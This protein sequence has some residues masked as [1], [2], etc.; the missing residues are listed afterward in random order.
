MGMIRLLAPALCLVL[1]VL[2]APTALAQSDAAP[3]ASGQQMADTRWEQTRRLLSNLNDRVKLLADELET[4]QVDRE[5]VATPGVV[6]LNERAD[7]LATE[8]QKRRDLYRF[9]E[10]I[11]IIILGMVALYTILHFTLKA[12]QMRQQRDPEAP[13]LTPQDVLNVSGLSLII[14][15]TLLVVMVADAEAQLTAAVGILGALAGYLFR[16]LHEK[17]ADAGTGARDRDAGMREGKG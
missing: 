8:V 10:I 4:V 1:N 13:G 12:D 17:R 16:G 9:I 15:G 3:Q 2:S 11:G 6:A 5:A 7:E 14:F